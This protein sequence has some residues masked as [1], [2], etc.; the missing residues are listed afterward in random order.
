MSGGHSEI[1]KLINHFDSGGTRE[2][3]DKGGKTKEE[4]G[5]MQKR[6]SRA[7]SYD[8]YKKGGKVK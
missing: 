1:D 2:S 6:K 7:S 3:F 8:K 4:V 5:K